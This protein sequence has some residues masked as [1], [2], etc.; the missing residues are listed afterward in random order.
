MKD[1]NILRAGVTVAFDRCR[2]V[3]REAEHLFVTPENEFRRDGAMWVLKYEGQSAKLKHR[4]G[5]PYIKELN[6]HPTKHVDAVE[7]IQR[8][9]GAAGTCEAVLREDGLLETIGGAS[10]P[11]DRETGE[12][13]GK[14]LDLLQEEV[15]DANASGDTERITEA[16]SRLDLFKKE[17]SRHYNYRGVERDSSDPREKARKAV[18]NA[19]HRAIKVI[20]KEM[21]LLGRHLGKS[22]KSSRGSFVYNPERQVT[23]NL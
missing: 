11:R 18:G 20:D 9:G 6:E 17:R 21:P 13:W 10:L 3:F 19:I 23:W 15:D 1:S 16:Q 22:I 8:Y 5:F 14:A 7:L 2:T 12:A 4:K